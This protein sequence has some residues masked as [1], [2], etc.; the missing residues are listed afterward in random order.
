MNIGSQYT[1]PMDTQSEI[2]YTEIPTVYNYQDN[3]EFDTTFLDVQV[4][5][6]LEDEVQDNTL[7]DYD[8]NCDMEPVKQQSD[9]ETQLETELE[10]DEDDDMVP[11]EQPPD[12]EVIQDTDNGMTEIQKL[13]QNYAQMERE[14]EEWRN[15]AQLAE[16][17]KNTFKLKL[18]KT[19]Q[20][21]TILAPMLV[22]SRAPRELKTPPKKRAQIE[23][24]GKTPREC[25]FCHEIDLTRNFYGKVPRHYK[26]CAF[27]IEMQ[28]T[29]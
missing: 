20:F 1:I 9:K 19:N 7:P 18:H 24:K 25:T 29:L 3:A 26:R 6:G 5:K 11:F 22:T 4:E 14:K 17:Q 2:P 15:K 10:D 16:E 23:K 28:K 27:L 12:D 13:Y 8:E 21:H